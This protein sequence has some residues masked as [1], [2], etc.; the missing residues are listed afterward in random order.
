MALLALVSR[1][2]PGG[3][4]ISVSVALLANAIGAVIYYFIRTRRATN[5]ILP[6]NLS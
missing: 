4:S 6:I 5:P 3:W 1:L 2:G